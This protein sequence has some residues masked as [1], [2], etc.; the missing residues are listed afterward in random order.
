MFNGCNFWEKVEFGL[1]VFMYVVCRLMLEFAV[2]SEWGFSG[3]M[4]VGSDAF[5]VIL[6]MRVLE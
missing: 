6:E 5:G 1:F 2:E 3:C 4:G